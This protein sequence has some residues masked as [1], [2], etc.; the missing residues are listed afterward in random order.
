MWWQVLRT[1]P[2]VRG[3]GPVLLVSHAAPRGLN[4]AP[5][6]AHRGFAAFRW[7]AD[8]LA[9]PLW[10]HGHTSLVRRG[11]DARSLRHGSTLLV[12]VTGA[13]LIDLVPPGAA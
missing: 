5:D 2:R 1:V 9:P 3:G 4:D 7:L 13:A 12:N 6:M 8:R 11:V 10:L